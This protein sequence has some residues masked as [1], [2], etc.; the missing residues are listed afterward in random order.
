MKTITGRWSLTWCC[1]GLHFLV[2]ALCVCC[3]FLLADEFPSGDFVGVFMTYNVLAF[4]TQPL[5][6]MLADRLTDRHYLLLGTA[7]LLL[8]LA[9]MTAS[10]ATALRW[11]AEA[12]MLTVAIL[13][14]MGNSLF[15]VWGGKLTAVRTENDGRALGVFVSTGA[16]GLAVGIFFHSWLLLYVLLL[17]IVLLAVRVNPLLTLQP[18]NGV[19][20]DYSKSQTRWRE[21][22]VWLGILVLM[23]LVMLR[24]L[25]G[26][27]FSAGID[28]GLYSVLLIGGVAMIGKMSG[29]W[30]ARWMGAITALLAVVVTIVVCM[31]LK[32][33]G[34]GMLWAGLLLVN[35]T[36]AITLYLANKLMRGSE[37]LVFGLLA[38][39]L[40][41]GYLLAQ[42]STTW[43]TVLPS[44]LLTL[45]PTIIIELGVLWLLREH[46]ASVL[47]PAVV[48]NILTN[49]PLNLYVTYVSDSLNT[50]IVAELLIIVVEAL[51]YHYFVRNL[52]MATI[53]SV[54]CNGMSFLLGLLIQLL[55]VYFGININ[56]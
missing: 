43:S 21:A 18:S 25:V 9:V 13:A 6:G 8:S 49:V 35:L 4:L 36:M 50:I 46:R 34:Q 52:R 23:G 40:M 17:L 48:V 7:V 15:H 2:D 53:Y 32:Q 30:I 41:P 12:V 10:A 19:G 54:L 22:W 3:L 29:G 37:G 24:S 33:W 31:L 55:L 26:E 47:W 56:L 51:W 44:L 14:G 38:A 45:V 28:K 27:T 5:T 20:A 11:S 16:F 39:A 1:S 42:F